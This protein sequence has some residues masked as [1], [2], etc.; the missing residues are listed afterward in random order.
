MSLTIDFDPKPNKYC[1]LNEHY[2]WEHLKS[3]WIRKFKNSKFIIFLRKVLFKGKLS[4]KIQA[5][6]Q[7]NTL[8]VMNRLL[9]KGK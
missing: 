4:I 5:I 7:I 3:Y 8:K 1:V 9:K 6:A 2:Q